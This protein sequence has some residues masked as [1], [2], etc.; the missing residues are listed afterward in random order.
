M[1]SHWRIFPAEV[2]KRMELPGFA[3]PTHTGHDVHQPRQ[4]DQLEHVSRFVQ[5][6]PSA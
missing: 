3:C 6:S 1:A 5:R 4:E 2:T